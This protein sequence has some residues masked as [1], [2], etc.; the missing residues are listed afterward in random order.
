MLLRIPYNIPHV[1]HHRVELSSTFAVAVM[2]HNFIVRWFAL[3][4]VQPT[5]ICCVVVYVYC[6]LCCRLF[7][8]P[9]NSMRAISRLQQQVRFLRPTTIATASALSTTVRALASSGSVASK[10]TATDVWDPTQYEKFR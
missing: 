2:R 9:T 4:S 1:S 6:D 10:T 3:P 5:V 8:V 7:I